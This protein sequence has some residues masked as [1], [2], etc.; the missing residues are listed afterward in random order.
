MDYLVP[1]FRHSSTS[2]KLNG[3]KTEFSQFLE[4][5]R[6]AAEISSMTP[7]NMCGVSQAVQP[8]LQIPVGPCKGGGG[9]HRKAVTAHIQPF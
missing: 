8:Q 9:M 5:S 6:K 2:T 7:F 1:H 3:E 4:V